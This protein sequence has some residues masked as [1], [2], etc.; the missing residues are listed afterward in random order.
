MVF[1]TLPGKKIINVGFIALSAFFVSFV[2]TADVRAKAV[3][4]KNVDLGVIK[5]IVRDEK[6]SP[7]SDAV[8]AI[9]RVGTSKI[10]KQVRSA[11]DGSFLA[12]IIPGTYT[13]LAIA[14]GFNASTISEV[15]VNR[16]AE[17]NYGFKLERAGGGNTLPEKRADR[18]SSKWRIRAAQIRRSI[19]QLKNGAAPV[20]ESEVDDRETTAHVDVEKDAGASVE[21]ISSEDISRRQGQSVVETYFVGSDEGNYEGFNFATL[22]PLDE[23]TEIILSVQTG[24]SRIAPSRFETTVKTRPNDNHQIRL[25]ASVAKVGTIKD[26]G[27]QLGQISFQAL[28]EWKV[29]EGIILVFGVDYS[30]FIGAGSDSSISPRF[31]LQFDA[32]SKTRFHTAYTM[33]NEERTWARAI[34]LED[35]SIFFREQTSSQP[36]AVEDAKPVM[37]KSR[38]LEFGVERVL[39]NNSNLEA[40]A[41]FDGIS[42]RGVGLASQ[43]LDVLNDENF[44]PFTIAQNG[45]TQG[46]RFVYTRRFGKIF[47]AS[48]GYAFGRGQKLSSEAISNPADIFEN[49]FFQTFAAQINTDLKTGT[50]IK[51]IFRLSPDAA[52]F[53]IDPFQGRLAIYDPS[54]SILITQNLPNLGLPIRAEAVLD[55]R[56]ILDYQTGGGE[57]GTLRLSSQGRSLRGGISVRF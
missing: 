48:A 22:Q 9:F 14:E 29:S 52:V 10:L 25:T 34:E 33:Q 3:I 2:S 20:D 53:A 32:G 55:A 27:K 19:Y 38:R 46:V 23:N 57:Q 47:S 17:I 21:D 36:I 16:S 39:D 7:I 54:L 28:D 35:T 15:E 42:G 1:S 5:G 18:D 50:R 37:N 6:G 24:T 45:K 4:E 13:V 56:N 26:A 51:T 44:A 49:S 8:V 41:F 11:S 12:K 31:G 43:P 30:R 40:T